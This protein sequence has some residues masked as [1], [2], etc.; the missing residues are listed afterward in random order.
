MG[1]LLLIHPKTGDVA[2]F[3]KGEGHLAQAYILEGYEPV[4]PRGQ[5]AAKIIRDRATSQAGA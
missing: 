2:T 3:R 1:M 4:G 5:A